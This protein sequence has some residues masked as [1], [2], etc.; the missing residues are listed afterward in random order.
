MNIL[1]A[2]VLTMVILLTALIKFKISPGLALFG[3]AILMSVLGGVSLTDMLG[4]LTS[5]FGGMMTSIGLIIIFGGVFGMMLGD[6]GGMEELAKGL[7]RKVGPK[8]DLLAMNLAGFIVSIPVYFGSAYIMMAPLV[9]SL[10]KL[11]AKKKTSY[12]AALFTGLLLTHCIVAPTPGPTAVAGQLGANLGWFILYGIV[13]SLPASLLCGWQYGNLLNAKATPEEKAAIKAGAKNIVENNELLKADPEKPSAVK[14]FLL[15]LFPILLILLGSIAPMVLPAESF[16]YMLLSFVGNNNIALFLAVIV[17]GIVLRK[18][19]VK[20]T[21]ISV[22]KYIDNV[23]DKLGNIL[24]VIGCGG[25]FGTVLQKCGLGDALVA[26][27]SGWN[28]PILLLA[29][30]LAMI[31]RA[32][33]GSATVAMLTTVSIIGASAVT[34]GYSPII[35][36]LSICAGTV[37]LTLPTDAAFWIPARKNDLTTSEAFVATTYSTTAASVVAFLMVLLLNLFVNTLPGMF[38]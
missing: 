35:V 16:A 17:T 32:A 5:G 13:V 2:F 33:V 9:G 26:L 29:F 8:N 38:S 21:G 14:I 18:Y 12:V 37:G 30:L 36:G 23:S 24:M 10:Q 20:N 31:I 19:L 34:M 4:Y 7:L 1:I 27:M 28:M 3:S 11:T 6:A 15:I 25:C 22:M